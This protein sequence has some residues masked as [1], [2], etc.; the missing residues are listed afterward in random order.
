MHYQYVKIALYQCGEWISSA[1]NLHS[2]LMVSAIL[3]LYCSYTS[4]QQ[5]RTTCISPILHEGFTKPIESSH[6][7]SEVGYTLILMRSNLVMFGTNPIFN[8]I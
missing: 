4:E 3:L 1:F 7:H 2:L 5:V 6:L 8:S